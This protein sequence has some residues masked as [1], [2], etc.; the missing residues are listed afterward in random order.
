VD[1][2][3]GCVEYMEWVVLIG[4]GISYDML[5]DALM[6]AGGMLDDD[7][8]YPIDDAIRKNLKKLRKR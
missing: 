2:S 1:P 6:D 3:D 5:L 4:L 8:S 7:V